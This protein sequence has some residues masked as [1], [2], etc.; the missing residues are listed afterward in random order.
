MFNFPILLISVIL[1]V[2][3]APGTSAAGA[4]AITRR[5]RHIVRQ[6]GGKT[7]TQ[8]D[9]YQGDNFLDGSWDFFDQ[10]DPTHGLVNYQNA[11]NAK[12][13]GLAVVEDGQL[14]LS[15]DATTQLRPGD[16]RD[17]IRISSKKTYNGGLFIADFAAMPV[18]CSVWPAWWTVGPDWPQGGEFVLSITHL[19]PFINGVIGEIDILEGVHNQPTNQYTLHTGAGCSA[20]AGAK[21]TGTSLGTTCQS[22]GTDNSGCAYRDTDPRSFGQT[23]NDAGGGVYAH[24]WD[25][26]GIKIWHFA[27]DEIPKDIPDNPNPSS[28]PTPAA[29]FPTSSCDTSQH[30]HDHSLTIDTTLC[31]DW[32]GA[33]YGSSGCPGTCEEAVAD[34]TNF[35]SE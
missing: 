11:D 14:I 3:L 35:V 22:S 15:V 7:Y 10:D 20:D 5:S 25:Q 32:A 21:T 13:K 18:G 19:I 27:R 1:I 23:F 8:V 9:K 17:S 26:D 29:D 4:P 28:W 24:L 31:G 33:V 2:N 30:F 12:S 34:P 6:G 16:K